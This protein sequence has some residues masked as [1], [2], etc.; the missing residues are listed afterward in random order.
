MNFLETITSYEIKFLQKK[1]PITKQPMELKEANI[2]QS[3]IGNKAHLRRLFPKQW[4]R[5]QKLISLLFSENPIS[6]GKIQQLKKSSKKTFQTI[7]N[8]ITSQDTYTLPKPI[9][10]RFQRRRVMVGGID[11][12]WQAD[13]VDVSALSQQNQRSLSVLWF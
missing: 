6:F 11:D 5:Y 13:L 1:G 12:Q 3:L 7:K 10:T 9:R 8:W 4:I 2:P